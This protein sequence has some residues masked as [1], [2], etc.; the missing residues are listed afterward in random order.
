MTFHRRVPEEKW[1]EVF[2]RLVNDSPDGTLSRIYVKTKLRGTIEEGI[3]PAGWPFRI[4]RKRAATEMAMCHDRKASF[5]DEVNWVARNLGNAKARPTAAPSNAAWNL[6][7][8]H[9]VDQKAFWPIYRQTMSGRAAEEASDRKDLVKD[10][11][12][13]R[14]LMEPFSPESDEDLLLAL[15]QRNPELVYK[16]AVKHRSLRRARL[17]AGLNADGSVREPTVAI[18]T[19][20]PVARL[21]EPIRDHPAEKQ[22]PIVRRERATCDS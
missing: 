17:R 10:H 20:E 13:L 14:K 19:L 7:V 8:A 1:N 5:V 21:S 16:M 18:S 4:S 15:L 22:D 6:L 11:D 3:D 12:R 9:V 2:Q